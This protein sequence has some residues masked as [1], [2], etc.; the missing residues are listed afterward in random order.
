MDLHSNIV[1]RLSQSI[2]NLKES[3]QWPVIPHSVRELVIA[4]LEEIL[5]KDCTEQDMNDLDVLADRLESL[6]EGGSVEIRKLLPRGDMR[7]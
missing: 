6:G 1:V 2:I 5:W 7:F 4:V 3:R